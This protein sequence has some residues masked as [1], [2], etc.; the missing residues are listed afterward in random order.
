MI[1]K[2]KAFVG[3]H[4]LRYIT[5]LTTLSK[6]AYQPVT[7]EKAFELLN[8][9]NTE[10]AKAIMT[11]VENS[12]FYWNRRILNQLDDTMKLIGLQCSGVQVITSFDIELTDREYGDLRDFLLETTSV[13][14]RLINFVGPIYDAERNRLET[15]ARRKIR[16]LNTE[17]DE[18]G[19]HF[20]ANFV[21]PIP[22][23]ERIYNK[24]RSNYRK[25]SNFL[26]YFV[27][28]EE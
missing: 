17:Y 1:F 11:T 16:E 3:E 7:L 2:M 19:I 20:V 13:Y 4:T 27:T 22:K 21:G 26:E 24:V 10:E 23:V 6:Y 28:E 18:L 15:I 8:L 12:R 5:T 25:L 14:H 9:S